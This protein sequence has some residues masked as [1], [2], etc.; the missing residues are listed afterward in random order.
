VIP[1][2]PRSAVL[3]VVGGGTR[4]MGHVVRSCALASVVRDRFG[5]DP[6]FAINRI[7]LVRRTVANAGF[8]TVDTAVEPDLW[9][10]D[11]PAPD[12]CLQSRLEGRL[13]ARMLVA[14]DYPEEGISRPHV[15]VDI[16]SRR[17]RAGG[18]VAHAE[19]LQFAIIRE[20]VIAASQRAARKDM[21]RLIIVLGSTDTAG[22]TGELLLSLSGLAPVGA[23]GIDVVLGPG[24]SRRGALPL[25]PSG[26]D[27]HLAPPELPELM[28]GAGWAVSNGGTTMLELLYLGV[29]C[30]VLPATVEE[31]RFA[32]TFEQAGAVELA[33]L[34][35]RR[36]ELEPLLNRFLNLPSHVL[37]RMAAAGRSLIDGHGAKR[38]VKVVD[39]AWRELGAGDSAVPHPGSQE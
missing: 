19:G 32:A 10:T 39:R 8:R 33:P 29:P 34:G 38:I 17:R 13:S 24:H 5:L 27:V 35:A 15:T 31:A 20:E 6:V 9:I 7:P 18:S 25:L 3:E 21:R 28:A 16:M 26:T 2:P 12:D 30:L 22:Q 23:A 4:G 1:N 14:L 36:R 11:V 37:A